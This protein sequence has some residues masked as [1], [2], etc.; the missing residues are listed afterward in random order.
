MRKRA[1]GTGSRKTLPF[2]L[3]GLTFFARPLT[4]D[5]DLALS[6]VADRYE[7][8]ELTG[9]RVVELMEEQAGVV[10]DLL[11]G[12]VQGEPRPLITP[13]WVMTHLGAQNLPRVLG[14]L[15][16]G[17]RPRE[18]LE[19]REWEQE[20][21]S[22]QDR[23]FRS[24]QLSFDEQRRAATLGDGGSTRETLTASLDLLAG[25]LTVRAVDGEPVT[26]EWLKANLGTEDIT[27]L[28]TY[29]QH[30]PDEEDEDPNAGEE[31]PAAD[32]SSTSA[33]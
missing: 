18:A 30:G 27:G 29:L 9:A 14:F 28:L 22:V 3:A 12:R 21:F 6:D 25:L 4:V 32:G 2:L 31:A 15:R 1:F 23:E 11:Q 13:T 5:E 7:T 8:E 20:P 33:A 17:E 10:T 26:A 19:L 24:L 16:T